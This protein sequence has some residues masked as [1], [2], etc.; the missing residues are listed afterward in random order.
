MDQ[1][2]DKA[3]LDSLVDAEMLYD[4]APC[5]YFSFTPNGLVIKVNQTLLDWLGYSR[6]EVVYNITFTDLIS[7]GGRIYYEMFYFPL[8]QLQSAVNEINFDFIRK[9]DSRFPALINSNV[10]RSESG[11]LLAVNATVYNITDRKKYEQE[12]LD[13]KKMADAERNRFESLSDFI[14]EMVWTA[15]ADGTLNYVNK[16]FINF[17]NLGVGQIDLLAVIKR[18]HHKDRLGLMKNWLKTIRTEHEFKSQIRFQDAVG[19]FQWYMVRAVALLDEDGSVSKWMGSCTDINEH[20]TAIEKLDEFISVA[21]HELKTP[22]TSLKGALQL[23]NKFKD[24]GNGLQLM[25]KLIEQSN[26]SAEKISNL[27]ADL[28]NTGNIKEG[29]MSLQKTRFNVLH[30]LQNTCPHVSDGGAYEL[31]IDA[32]PDLEVSADE[33]RIDQILV[34]FVNNAIKY[35]PNSKRIYLRAERIAEMEVKISVA[36]LGPGIAAEKLPY[37]FERYYRIDS[38]GHNYSGL[39]LGLYI[40]AEI[41]RKHGGK[42]G[43]ESEPG[44][45]TTF[46]FTLPG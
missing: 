33:N 12:L 7:R 18:I 39:G 26:R 19:T 25:P 38:S 2:I 21:S 46:W 22:I 14:P 27:V 31:V 35:A 10:I 6:A 15:S 11:E 36:D 40:C 44:S 5:G 29:Q 1:P 41:V 37:V 45:G 42:I 13:A 4:H 16:R 9:D 23:M 3:F 24:S 8:L 32:D 43:V 17:F 30:A 28:L 34:N 20:V